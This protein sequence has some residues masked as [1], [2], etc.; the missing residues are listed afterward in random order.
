MGDALS[1]P[2]IVSW[3]QLI[4]SLGGFYDSFAYWNNTIPIRVTRS[5]KSWATIIL[6]YDLVKH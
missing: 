3:L 1:V 5:E 4:L 6:I 2:F